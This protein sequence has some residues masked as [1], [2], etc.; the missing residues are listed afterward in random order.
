MPASNVPPSFASGGE[1]ANQDFSIG[2]RHGAAIGQ[3]RHPRQ[4]AIRARSVVRRRGLADEDPPAARGVGGGG[5]DAV[6]AADLDGADGRIP[7]VEL[8]VGEHAATL[9]RLRQPFR[10]PVLPDERDAD[11]ARSRRDGHADVET[12]VAGQLHVGFPFGR[13]GEAGFAV[14]GVARRRGPAGC[15]AADHEPLDQFPV[16]PHV[17]LLRPA[18]A[19]QVVLILPAQPHLDRVVAVHRKLVTNRDAAARAEWQIFVLSI[20]LHHVKRNL[21]GLEHRHRRRHADCEARDLS[22]RGEIAFEMRGGDREDIRKIIEA[23]VGGF[24]AGEQ[25]LHIKRLRV[26]REE[27]AH[28]VA[29]LRA[30]EAMDRADAARHRRRTPCSIDVRFKPRGDRVQRLLRSGRGRPA[31]GIVPAR[32]RAITFSQ[33]S[34]LACGDAASTASSARPAVLIRWL[35][36]VTQ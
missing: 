23:A 19:H 36:H 18:H 26:Q 14:A 2:R 30:V 5:H 32:S 31:G 3:A 20:L 22:R 21:E 25:C 1:E 13:A 35:W 12:R 17:E 8:I 10:F 11:H 33:I 27:I 9:Q 4:D 34:G 15:R 28:G 16:E 7:H 29:V 24:V 6:R